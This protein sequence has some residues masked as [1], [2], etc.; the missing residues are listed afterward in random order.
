MRILSAPAILLDVFNLQERDRIVCFL[1][2]EWGKKRGVARGARAKFSR[3]AGHLQPLAK[4]QVDWFEKENSDLVRIN[5]IS[6]LRPASAL[7]TDLEGILLGSYLAEHMSEFAME[8]EESEK[9]FRLLDTTL[10]ALLAGADRALA[11]RYFEIWVLR[12]SG[13]FPVPRECPSCGEP[14]ERRAWV[15]PGDSELVCGNCVHGAGEQ[16]TGEQRAGAPEGERFE[17]GEGVIDFLRRSARENLDS[18]AGRAPT[19][20]VLDRTERLCAK[21]RRAFLQNELKSYQVMRR[22]L[23]GLA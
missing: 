14:I 1:T 11:A 15:Q 2:S 5:D 16:G 12:L 20:A 13:I 10:E 18:L 17:V 22:T 9:Y 19:P 21:I 3:F 23:A 7:Q 6:L 8:N 4:V